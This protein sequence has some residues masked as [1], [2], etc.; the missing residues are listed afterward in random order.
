MTV[1]QIHYETKLFFY[2]VNWHGV[3]IIV[4]GFKF[5]FSIIHMLVILF[6]RYG[7]ETINL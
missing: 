1:S 3:G 5:Q 7:T 4:R 6:V 2:D